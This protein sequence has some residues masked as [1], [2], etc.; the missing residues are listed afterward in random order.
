MTE[1]QT[2]KVQRDLVSLKSSSDD[3]DGV[4][5]AGD[6]E[7]EAGSL[8]HMIANKINKFENNQLQQEQVGYSTKLGR[9]TI[10]RLI[11]DISEVKRLY[12]V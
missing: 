6:E 10:Q 8:G 3:E 9:D 11:E 1:Q 5:D 12:K 4:C 7:P 2:F